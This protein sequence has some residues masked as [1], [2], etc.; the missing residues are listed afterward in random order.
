MVV[1]SSSIYENLFL[2]SDTGLMFIIIHLLFYHNPE[3]V[4]LI[5]Y[6]NQL[7]KM[8]LLYIENIIGVLKKL[9][10]SMLSPFFC[11]YPQK[12]VQQTKPV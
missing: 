12:S 6:L 3:S 9:N 7:I 8:P 2:K 11:S 5:F 4:K 1:T 10:F